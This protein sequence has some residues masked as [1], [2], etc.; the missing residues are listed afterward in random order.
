MIIITSFADTQSHSNNLDA[1]KS[2]Y[3]PWAVMFYYG[4]MTNNDLGKVLTSSF[5]LSKEKLY[6]V[7]F[8]HQLP[9]ANAFM[10]F[11]QPLV[12]TIDVVGNFTYRDDPLGNIYEVNPYL[13]FRWNH[14]PWNKYVFT[15]FAV[16]EGLSYDTK[17]PQIEQRTSTHSQS[18]LNFLLFEA[19]FAMP[20]HP[21]W[22]LVARVHHRSGVFGLYNA[23]NNGSTAVGLGIRY[24]F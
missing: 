7:E 11:F 12:S 10:Q 19:T 23:G 1:N 8:S 2:S 13:A 17:V 22:E 16:G 21:N 6:S 4:R 3:Y 15:S 5:T 24:R 18:L 14:F 20:S 9:S